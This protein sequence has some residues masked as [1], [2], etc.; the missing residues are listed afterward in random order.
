MAVVRLH[1][2]FQSLTDL[3]DPTHSHQFHRLR[4]ARYPGDCGAHLL[5]PHQQG[6]AYQ[7]SLRK[8]MADH[9][10]IQDDIESTREHLRSLLNRDGHDTSEIAEDMRGG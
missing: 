5:R 1:S 10:V 8:V 6:V 3:F 4:Q 9:E 2:L 7:I